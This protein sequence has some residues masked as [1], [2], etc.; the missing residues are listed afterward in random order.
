VRA[1]WLTADVPTCL[2]MREIVFIVS[3]NSHDLECLPGYSSLSIMNQ[4]DARRPF[5]SFIFNKISRHMRHGHRRLDKWFE[6][7]HYGPT[8]VMDFIITRL[9][10][11]D[12]S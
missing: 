8:D 4:N 10:V 5:M 3:Q 12:V 1:R 7:A 6:W 2:S 9:K 11:I